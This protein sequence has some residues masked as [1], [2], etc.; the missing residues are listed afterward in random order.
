MEEKLLKRVDELIAKGERIL[1]KKIQKPSPSVYDEGGYY[2]GIDNQEI[3]GL[4][5]AGRSFIKSVYGVD[6]PHYRVF[7]TFS[8]ELCEDDLKSCISILISIKEEIEGGWLTSLK[9]LVSA[10]IFSD[11]LEMAEHLL[12][13]GY[14][15]PAAVMIGSILE[16]HLRQLCTAKGIDLSFTNSKGELSPKKADVLN[17]DLRKAGAYNQL[18]QKQVTFSLGLRN[19]AAHGHYHKYTKEQVEL[20]FQGVQNFIARNPA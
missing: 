6:H 3:P 1:T 7:S 14:K 9:G 10:E 19:D 11:F 2:W 17:A 15:D 16:E 5:A 18:D 20:M 4:W 8:R 12:T 13:E